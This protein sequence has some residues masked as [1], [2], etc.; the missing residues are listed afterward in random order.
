LLV[1][2]GEGHG[3]DSKKHGGEG[4]F[5][6]EILTVTVTETGRRN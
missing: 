4:A 3:C 5:Y 6:G 2:D 1:F